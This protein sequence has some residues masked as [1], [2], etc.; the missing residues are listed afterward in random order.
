MVTILYTILIIVTSTF[1]ISLPKNNKTCNHIQLGQ[2][3]YEK[4]LIWANLGRPYNL[5]VHKSTNILFFSYSLPESYTDLDF[6]LACYDMDKKVY[7]VV[8]GIQGGCTIA[9]DQDNDE[10]YLGGSDGIFKFNMLTRLADIYKEEGQNIWSLFYKK[11]LFYVS[12][13]NQKLHIYIDGKFSRVREFENFEVDLF[14][15]TNTNEVYFTNKTGLYTFN[16]VEMK[17]ES[18]NEMITVRQIAEDNEEKLFVC[19]NLGIYIVTRFEGLKK[20][21]DMRN[22]FGL[23]FDK[24]NNMIY[25][26][27]NSI[28]KLKKSKIG[29]SSTEKP[30]W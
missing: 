22:A 20:I 29:C 1:S 21:T 11:N 14:H 26:N 2:Q 24:E 5:N 23:T 28:I 27:D 3:W 13:P 30:Y 8:A 17:A 7:Q 25:S 15:V 18:I 9:I 10:I 12:Y 6:T 19:T 16:S 4:E